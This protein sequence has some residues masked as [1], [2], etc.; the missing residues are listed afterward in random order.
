[1]LNRFEFS[2]PEI[3]ENDVRS[4]LS[5]W[6]KTGKIGRIWNKDAGVWTDSDENKWLGWLEIA[7]H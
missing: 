2:L 7:R 1:M 6:K 4:N 3:I 5:D